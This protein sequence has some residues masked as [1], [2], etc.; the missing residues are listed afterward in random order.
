MT[1]YDSYLKTRTERAITLQQQGAF[2]VDKMHEL[3]LPAPTDLHYSR[4]WDDGGRYYDFENDWGKFC[5]DVEQRSLLTL[6]KGQPPV[7]FSNQPILTLATATMH[8][9]YVAI[10][11][12]GSSFDLDMN[13]Q[14]QLDYSMLRTINQTLQTE[15][16]PVVIWQV[17]QEQ[18]SNTPPVIRITN[19]SAM[20]FASSAIWSPDDQQL[21]AAQVVTTS[22]ELLKAVKATLANN[23]SKSYLTVKTPD[24]SAFLKGAKRGFV[25]VNANLAQ[26]NADG[27]VTAMLHPLSGD[28][29]ASSAD[30]CYIVVSPE[31][32]ISKKFAERLD[33]SIPWPIQTEWADYLLEA[34][35]DAGLVQ[36][37]PGSGKDF[38][39]GLRLVK[40]ESKWQQVIANGLKENRI[41]IS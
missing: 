3:P 19:D 36:V 15:N 5:Y 13:T 11:N 4:N 20:L 16:I 6:H 41:R 35:Q 38:A 28:P 30:Y 10:H 40:N 18:K 39:A 14:G 33:L 17:D 2:I 1:I 27:T 34:G 26:A 12:N 22:N 23:S 25:C 32:S 9:G 7:E 29:Q 8:T 37:L 21:V 24:D 31:E